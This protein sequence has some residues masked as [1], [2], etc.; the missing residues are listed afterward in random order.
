MQ[1]RSKLKPGQKGTRKL[2][3]LYGPRLVCVRYRYD[4]HQQKRF[5]TVEIIVEEVPWT[6]KPKPVKP[7]T[8]IAVRVEYGEV[9]LGR[10]VK[11]AGGKWNPAK[12]VWEIR[13]DQAIALGLEERIV[14]NAGTQAKRGRVEKASNTRNQKASS[15]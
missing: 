5:K 15:S 6:P 8:I 3:E 10:R 2:V 13:Y 12:R 14:R 4:E 9:E 7:A 11:S 1:A